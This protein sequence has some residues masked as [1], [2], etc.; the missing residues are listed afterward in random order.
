MKL[1]RAEG[2]LLRW[3]DRAFKQR[4]KYYTNA[5]INTNEDSEN[6]T[7]SSPPASLSCHILADVRTLRIQNDIFRQKLIKIQFKCILFHN[8]RWQTVILSIKFHLKD[9]KYKK[10]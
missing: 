10:E 9:N 5:R 8:S 6:K 4:H 2:L 7:V 1:Q 3:E